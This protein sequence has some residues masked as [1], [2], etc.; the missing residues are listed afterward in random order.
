MNKSDAIR[1]KCLD[2][3][4]SPKE[5]TLC[6]IVDCP[7][8]PFRFGYSIKDKRYRQRMEA[9]KKR[10]PKEYKEMMQLLLEYPINTLNLAGFVQ[11]DTVFNRKINKEGDSMHLGISA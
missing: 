11:I 2:C 4:G 6:H 7:L 9:A 5:V 1:K 10:Y 3:S 8:W